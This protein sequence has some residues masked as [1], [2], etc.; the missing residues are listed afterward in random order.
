VQTLALLG[1]NV[2]ELTWARQHLIWPAG[3]IPINLL[4]LAAAWIAA[5]LRRSNPISYALRRHP[6]PIDAHFR[7]CLVLTYSIPEDVL[8]LLLPP[9]LQVDSY[10]G[11][12]FLAVAIVRTESLRP[13]RLPRQLGRSFVLTGYRIFTKFHDGRHTLRGLR[14]LR[15]DANKSMM[16]W[17]GNLLTHYNY[18]LC[19]ASLSLQ[20]SSLR[21]RITTL[22]G[23]ADLELDAD[24]SGECDAPL[25]GDSPFTS[26]QDARR[27]AG[28]LPWTFD[29]ERE[30]HSIIAIKGVRREWRPR[31][32]PVQ[33]KQCNFLSLPAFAG[34]TPVLASAF[35]VSDIAYR[36]ERG[37]RHPLDG[38]SQWP[39]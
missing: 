3:L 26:V 21:V 5:E 15:S 13:A 11:K 17:G 37:V 16:V 29:Y 33:V 14:I 30:T 38:A 25:P 18:Q 34:A 2:M 24:L 6:I 39:P 22:H 19:R 4:F 7:H 23:T 28:P 35:Y 8:G 1:M 36:W 27:F 32:V 31:I 12:G 9:G 10:H 20:G